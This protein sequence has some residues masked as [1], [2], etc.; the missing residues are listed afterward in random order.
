MKIIYFLLTTMGHSYCLPKIR[1]N[2][3]DKKIWKLT[4]PATLN[5]VMG[6]VV[7]MIDTFWIG[8][9]GTINQ[10]ASSGSADQLFN[11]FYMM[12]IF[13]P[14]IVGPK[15][16]EL[17]L[18]NKTNEIKQLITTSI[19]LTNM[20][21]LMSMCIMIFYHSNL[22]N[23]FLG[24]NSVLYSEAREYFVYRTFGI[25]F[26]LNNCMMFGILRGFMEINYATKIIFKSQMINIVLNPFFMLLFGIKGVAIAS[27]LSD[28]YACYKYTNLFIDKNFFTKKINHFIKKSL[29]L[30]KQGTFIQI[31]NILVQL[32]YL[33]TTNCVSSMDTCGEL[34]GCHIV[35]IKLIQLTQ[36]SYGGL[37]SVSSVLI[38]YEKINNND[39]VVI[40]YLLKW[41]F[42]VGIIQ[43]ILIY[44][45]R[46]QLHFFVNEENIV[47]IKSLIQ[48]I[49]I[50]QCI[51]GI[52][53]IFEG[54]LQGY[55]KFKYS[56]IGSMIHIIPTFFILYFSK[57]LCELWYYCI[58]PLLLKFVYFN[59][60]L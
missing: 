24:N 60:I 42:Y 7:G 9:L 38:P 39:K 31:K 3:I 13:L 19:I 51:Y 53:H 57:T 54:I 4:K 44:F 25:C 33:Y 29:L 48:P 43:S 5:Y 35:I 18:L 17:K 40:S 52:G 27:V 16:T 56:F 14:S 26:S 50:Y 10:L 23:L 28:V 32:M 2:P 36:I 55:Q 1:T 37:Y 11:M 21:S 47:T 49:C 15:I 46:E 45:I 6:P 58:I 30:F 41:G 8:K 20:L 34:L 22:L 59:I 12:N